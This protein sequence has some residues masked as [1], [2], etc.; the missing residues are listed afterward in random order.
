[1]T[2]APALLVGGAVAAGWLQGRLLPPDAAVFASPS[3]IDDPPTRALVAGLPW[4][5]AGVEVLPSDGPPPPAGVDALP[6]LTSDSGPLRW[7]SAHKFALVRALGAFGDTAI[8]VPRATVDQLA[9]WAAVWLA[10][11]ARWLAAVA[12]LSADE[13][14]DRRDL[15]GQRKAAGEELRRQVERL[16]NLQDWGHGA[17]VERAPA[18]ATTEAIAAYAVELSP[19][20]L[21]AIPLPADEFVSGYARVAAAARWALTAPARGLWDANAWYQGKVTGVAARAAGDAA[22]AAGA[23]AIEALAGIV[24]APA[25]AALLLVGGYLLIRR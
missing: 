24:T 20:F 6:P 11:H 1:M 17:F 25:G 23:A 10:A 8:A 5:V 19:S 12:L 4:H 3:V 2:I 22:S 14:S 21:D 7:Y 13:Y 16:H 9:A 18:V 15:F